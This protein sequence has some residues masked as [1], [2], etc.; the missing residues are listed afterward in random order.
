MT[1]EDIRCQALPPHACA[2][3]SLCICLFTR[4]IHTVSYGYSSGMQC[5]SEKP[6]VQSLALQN[7]STNQSVDKYLPL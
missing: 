3:M 2:D 4:D 7:K 1:E 5:L 6:R